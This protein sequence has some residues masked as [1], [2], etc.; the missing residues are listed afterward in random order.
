MKTIAEIGNDRLINVLVKDKNQSP[1]RI[2]NILKSEITNVISSYAELDD[3]IE[4]RMTTVRGRVC[5]EIKA[6]ATR[7]KEFGQIAN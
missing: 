5:F 1:A 6:V 4:I 7:I 2:I 3:E